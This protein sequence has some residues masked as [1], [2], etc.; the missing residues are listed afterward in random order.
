MQ[1]DILL[2]KLYARCHFIIILVACCLVLNDYVASRTMLPRCS[3]LGCQQVTKN[4]SSPHNHH[5]RRAI[6]ACPCRSTWTGQDA[7]WSHHGSCLNPAA[8]VREKARYHRIRWQKR[9]TCS[10]NEE[11]AYKLALRNASSLS[12]ATPTAESTAGLYRRHRKPSI[13][14]LPPHLPWLPQPSLAPTSLL[15]GSPGVAT[16]TTHNFLTTIH[17]QHM[18]LY[19]RHLSFKLTYGEPFSSDW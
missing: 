6:T 3:G 4:P 16:K 7:A 9:I 12:P 5:V 15:L 17:M 2:N 1:R 10:A 8:S 11:G 19:I 14:P 18:W 13:S